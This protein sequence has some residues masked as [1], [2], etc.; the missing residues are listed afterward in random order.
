MEFHEY[1]GYGD[2]EACRA[3]IENPNVD[4]NAD[5]VERGTPISWL[6]NSSEFYKHKPKARRKPYDENDYLRIATFVGQHWP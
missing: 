1:A 4:I 2:V 5:K 6:W 3:L